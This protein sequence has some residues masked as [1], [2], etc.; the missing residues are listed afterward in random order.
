MSNILNYPDHSAMQIRSCLVKSHI[1]NYLEEPNI[2]KEV[3][4]S[5]FYSVIN[6]SEVTSF[7]NVVF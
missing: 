3:L 1:V 6:L 2:Q 7:S 4:G 5:S